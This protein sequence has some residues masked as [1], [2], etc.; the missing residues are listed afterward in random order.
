MTDTNL[1]DSRTKD[2]E[3]KPPETPLGVSSRSGLVGKM[4]RITINS[5]AQYLLRV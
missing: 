4:Q 2:A 1:T 5:L 3:D